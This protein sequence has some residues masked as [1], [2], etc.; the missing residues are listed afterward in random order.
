MLSDVA[1]QE[2]R[3]REYLAQGDTI[4]AVKLAR[5]YFGYDLTAAKA[6]VERLED[7]G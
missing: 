6:Y 4:T 1:A 3:I 2:A 7:K 5:H